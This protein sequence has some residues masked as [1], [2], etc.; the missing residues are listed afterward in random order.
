[1]SIE[2]PADLAGL[3]HAG[4]ITRAVLRAQTVFVTPKGAQLLTA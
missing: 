4:A 2:S 3:K 1:M